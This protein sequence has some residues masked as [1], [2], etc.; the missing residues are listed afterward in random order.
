MT[1]SGDNF[2]QGQQRGQYSYYF[3]QL[4]HCWGWA[5][6]R[7]SWRLYHTAID[8]FKE[9]M[10]EQSYQDFTHYPLANIMWRKNFYKTLQREINTWDYL[11]VFASF[12]NHGLTILP[13]QNLV[14]NI[15]FG[16]DATHTTGTSRG[17]GIVETDSVTFPL[18]HPP[19]MCL[20]K[21]ADT[22]SYQ[23]HFRVRPKQ[24]KGALHRLLSFLKAV[25]NA[26]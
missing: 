4:P 8:H 1:I 20:H 19:Y 15:G 9:I 13:Q 21:E 12:V 2:Q 14:K 17:Y 16:K 3:S 25:R 18:Q 26:K 22:F 7:R 5:S 24:Q 23:T 11:W 10:A 6:W